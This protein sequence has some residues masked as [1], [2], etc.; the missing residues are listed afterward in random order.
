MPAEPVTELAPVALNP[1]S[2]GIPLTISW[3]I[4]AVVS[5]PRKLF[6]PEAWSVKDTVWA[7]RLDSD[8]GDVGVIVTRA[9]SRSY[10]VGVD[11]D[12]VDH[13]GPTGPRAGH[14]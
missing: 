10:M 2:I 3:G 11:V 4:T 5:T 6:Q 12:V 1:T 7:L 13:T 9:G 14:H 8:T